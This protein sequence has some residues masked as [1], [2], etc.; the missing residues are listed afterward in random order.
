LNIPGWVLS[1]AAHI[2]LAASRVLGYSPMLTPG[3]ARELTQDDW[4]CNNTALSAATG[5]SPQITLKT[6]VS[7]LFGEAGNPKEK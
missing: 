4:L 7:S 1:G 6:G 2:N 3:K 5:W